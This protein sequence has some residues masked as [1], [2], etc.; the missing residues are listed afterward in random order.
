MAQTDVKMSELDDGVRDYKL[1]VD[2]DNPFDGQIIYLD[3]DGD[4]EF[5]IIGGKARLNAGEINATLKNN[6]VVVAGFDPWNILVGAVRTQAPTATGPEIVAKGNQ[7]KVEFEVTT[8]MTTPE[9]FKFEI[10][11]RATKDIS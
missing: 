1:G 3:L 2:I 4:W 9:K 10:S 7:L 11:C 6:D 8:G 5:E